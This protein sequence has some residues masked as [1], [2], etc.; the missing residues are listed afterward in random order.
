MDLAFAII[1]LKP[2]NFIYS[3]PSHKWDGNE[4]YDCYIDEGL[5]I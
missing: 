3:Y 5:L 4:L 2:L 1:W